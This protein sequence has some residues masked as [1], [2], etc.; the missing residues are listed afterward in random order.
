[1]LHT[2]H[3]FRLIANG[4]EAHGG[5]NLITFTKKECRDCIGNEGTLKTATKYES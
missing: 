2:S 1:M 3:A 4:N 5:L